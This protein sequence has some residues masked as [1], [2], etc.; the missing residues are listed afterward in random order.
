ML[1]SSDLSWI[2]VSDIKKARK[3]FT[4]TLGLV[5]HCNSEEHGWVE[6]GGTEGGAKIGIA[7]AN[8][9]DRAG[10]NAVITFSVNHLE[11]CV[12]ELKKK[13]VKMIG[14]IIEVPG[15]VKL[16]TFVDTARGRIRFQL[17]ETL[18]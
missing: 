8:N 13:G 1:K 12:A 4:E 16:Q 7:Q 2:V 10:T 15:H 3:F 5:E 14:E 9:E 11:N 17:V 6:V 18:F